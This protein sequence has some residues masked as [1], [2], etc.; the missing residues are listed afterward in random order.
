MRA[1][2]GRRLGLSGR[3]LWGLV[4]AAGFGSRF[5]GPLP[6]QYLP[7]AGEVVLTQTLR[8]LDNVGC[9]AI[10]LGLASGDP[11]WPLYKPSLKTA[12]WQYEGGAERA[13]T[14][15]NG[16]IALADRAAPDDL[17]LVHDA[18][19][20]C[21]R[22][23][24]LER[25]VAVAMMHAEG[26]LL[27]RPV[28]DTVKRSD[29][30]GAVLETVDRSGLWLAHTPQVFRYAFLQRALSEAITTGYMVT[31]EASAIERLGGHPM[32]VIGSPDNIKITLPEDLAL[33]ELYLARQR[34][35]E[36]AHSCV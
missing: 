20:P 13:L 6:K 11:Y 32:L 14:V 33:A 21:V 31:D 4:P 5:K 2:L 26:A 35:E 3:R 29:A 7:L 34:A 19:R 22:A 25:L 1:G 36:Q 12:L 24:D 10:G 15:F 9:E 27:A 16:L 18:A 23:A 17:I 30:S 28:A 8:R